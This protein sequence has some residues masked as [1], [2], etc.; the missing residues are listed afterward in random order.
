[1]PS[2]PGPSTPGP[3][4]PGPDTPGPGTPTT[5][6]PGTGSEMGTLIGIGLLALGCGAGILSVRRRATV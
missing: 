4:T 6:L 3:S 5:S 1:G 2:T